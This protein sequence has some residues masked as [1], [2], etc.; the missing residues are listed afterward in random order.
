MDP[1]KDIIDPPPPHPTTKEK[2]NPSIAKTNHPRPPANISLSPTTPYTHLCASLQPSYLEALDLDSKRIRSALCSAAFANLTTTPP[3][4]INTTALLNDTILT[5]YQQYTSILFTYILISTSTSTPEADA[6][7]DLAQANEAGVENT[8][9]KGSVV[10]NVACGRD[11]R[12][13]SNNEALGSVARWST[14]VFL[15][16]LENV[17]VEVGWMEWLCGN[18]S[19]EAMDVLGLDG[20]AAVEEVCGGGR[21]GETWCSDPWLC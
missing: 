3:P 2:T 19:A 20:E 11:G 14:K 17:S 13:M 5:T 8:G 21:V 4:A 12:R 7:C 1:G 15:Q 16:V 18:L 9:L 10:Y 6:L